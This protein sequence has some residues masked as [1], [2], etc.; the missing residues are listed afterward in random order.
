VHTAI[1]IW[2]TV[3][4]TCMYCCVHSARHDGQRNCPKHVELY[5]KNTFEKLVHLIGFIIRIYHD[6]RS[7]ECQFFSVS[8]SQSILNS[9]ER[10]NKIMYICFVYFNFCEKRD[11]NLYLYPNFSHNSKQHSL[12]QEIIV[13][14]LVKNFLIF[15]ET[16]KLMLNIRQHNVILIVLLTE[17]LLF[18]SVLK[19]S[20]FS[21]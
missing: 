16:P 11:T 8:L 1:G 20:N 19:Y 7:S 14:W 18:T 10:I 4:I 12:C 17:L 2:H 5:S 6:A 13:I 15:Y 3:S 9:Y 21:T